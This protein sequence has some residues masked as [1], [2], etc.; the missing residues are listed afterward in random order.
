M[1]VYSA[2][3]P[4]IAN[5]ARLFPGQLRV[6]LQQPR[7]LASWAHFAKD[8]RGQ[9]TRAT[10]STAPCRRRLRRLDALRSAS[11]S[12]GFVRTLL[13]VPAEQLRSDSRAPPGL[14]GRRGRRWG[15]EC[16]EGH[17]IPRACPSLGRQGR[18]PAALS[19]PPAPPR[20]RVVLWSPPRGGGARH[21]QAGSLSSAAATGRG[22]GGSPPNQASPRPPARAMGRR[23]AGPAGHPQ[24]ASRCL[25]ACSA[26][27]E[28]D[29][30]PAGCSSE[31]PC[32]RRAAG[33]PRCARRT[34][35]SSGARLVAS[36]ALES[37][38][39]GCGTRSPPAAGGAGR[40]QGARAREMNS[41]RPSSRLPLAL[42]GAGGGVR[43]GSCL[44][45][46]PCTGRGRLGLRCRDVRV[47]NSA[48]A[49]ADAAPVLRARR[50]PPAQQWRASRVV[51]RACCH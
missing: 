23:R 42:E 29:S 51:A 27:R 40:Q 24:A 38:G 4:I 13:G 35:T 43:A 44:L 37:A 17:A 5:G 3:S 7:S 39:G 22:G 20:A 48:L 47:P 9:A 1:R 16:T 11:R 15:R 18:C 30:S 49:A 8:R 12:R 31:A 21:S 2:A 50:A 32:G 10:R 45:R 26:R 28:G 34:V 25:A 33:G 14:R 46:A 41:R 19:L 36:C 6:G